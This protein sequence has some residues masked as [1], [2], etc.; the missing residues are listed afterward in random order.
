MYKKS[1]KFRGVVRLIVETNRQAKLGTIRSRVC[2]L[3]LLTHCISGP[4]PNGLA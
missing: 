1:R 2:A 4:I 3:T